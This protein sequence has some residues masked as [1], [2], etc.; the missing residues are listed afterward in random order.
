MPV[1]KDASVWIKPII[2]LQKVKTLEGLISPTKGDFLC[3]GIEGEQWTIK[4]EDLQRRYK[5]T[6]KVDGEWMEYQPNPD[7]CELWARELEEIT[8]IKTTFGKLS[9][10]K[11]DYLIK[12]TVPGNIEPL[13]YW[14]IKRR[15]FIKSYTIL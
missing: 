15:I 10:C 5:P 13:S 2:S 14:I 8:E 12:E 4:K 3:K 7:A 6:G 1:I 9:G 11:G